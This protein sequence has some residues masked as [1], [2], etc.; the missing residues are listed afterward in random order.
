[1]HLPAP[2]THACT[3][4]FLLTIKGTSVSPWEGDVHPGNIPRALMSSTADLALPL[5]A[6]SAPSSLPI[7]PP[8]LSL[9]LPSSAVLSLEINLDWELHT[10]LP[11]DL[12]MS[13]LYPCASTY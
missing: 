8:P 3:T 13:L 2:P 11:L 9:N 10:G 5:T 1:M 12:N 6:V 4:S 7:S